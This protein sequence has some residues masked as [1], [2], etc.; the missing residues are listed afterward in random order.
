MLGTKNRKPQKTEN[1]KPDGQK[2]SMGWDE[3]ALGWGQFYQEYLLC[4][5]GGWI[6]LNA[7]AWCGRENCL[8]W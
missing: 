6:G 4:P 7:G 5:S 3:N 1:I 2:T 8:V